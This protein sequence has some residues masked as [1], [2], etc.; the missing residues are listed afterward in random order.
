LAESV[1]KVRTPFGRCREI[2]GQVSL[3]TAP[4][5][6][7]I[8]RTYPLRSAVSRKARGVC[9]QS[10]VS[11]LSRR[12][13]SSEAINQTCSMELCGQPSMTK[14]ILRSLAQLRFS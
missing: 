11:G 14:S 3:M 5:A 8:M 4:P 9:T 1:A 2:A 7:S 10:A 6:S 13:S 12:P